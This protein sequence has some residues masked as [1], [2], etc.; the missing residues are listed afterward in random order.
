MSSTTKFVLSAIGVVIGL[1]LIW[2][3]V[4]WLLS[5]AIP[6]AI[7]GAVIYVIYLAVSRKSISGRGG[8][9]LP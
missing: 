2:K 5:I 1:V 8:R 9:S 3:F 7:A 6:I 4:A